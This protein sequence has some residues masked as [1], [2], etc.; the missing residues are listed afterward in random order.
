MF[1]TLPE[2]FNNISVFTAKW[3]GMLA[4]PFGSGIATSLK[5]FGLTLLFALP[6]GLIVALGE[7]AKFRLISAP[8]K[9]FVMVMRGTPLMLQLLFVYFAPFYIFGIRG[10]YSRFVAVIIAFTLNYAAYFA[11]IY[12]GGIQSM[13]RGQYE[14]GAVLGFTQVQVFL[15]IILPQVIKRVLPPFSN[16]VITLVKDTAL[17]QILGVSDLLRAAQNAASF[18]FSVV[19]FMFSA[20]VY[21]ILCFIIER[22]FNLGEKRLSYYR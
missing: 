21:F 2:L 17:V 10:A 6:L 8:V 7:M 4:G 13:P 20:V 9:F 15:K 3:W 11:E 16:E 12:R 5:V 19:P 22:L 1:E 18:T 14:A